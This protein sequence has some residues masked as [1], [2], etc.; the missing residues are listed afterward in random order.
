MLLCSSERAGDGAI[1]VGETACQQ[2]GQH[3]AQRVDVAGGGRC[4]ARGG[5][6]GGDK[7]DAL[8]EC[9]KLPLVVE[10][11][12]GWMDVRFTS[13]REL[14]QPHG[15]GVIGGCVPCCGL[16]NR[17]QRN[18]TMHNAVA[19][20]FRN[21]PRDCK[22]HLSHICEPPRTD[23]SKS[24][25]ERGAFHCFAD[26]HPAA[27][28]LLQRP[29]LGDHWVADRGRLLGGLHHRFPGGRIVAGFCLQNDQRDVTP[30]R[31]MPG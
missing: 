12:P 3:A 18:C 7:A 21:R 15:W 30:T 2:G 8:P 10:R 28:G 27:S 29:G 24:L 26:D 16:K 19:V 31:L 5:E 22:N 25:A 11:E 13:Q 9:L 6:F 20:E 4:T 17:V 14:Q 23:V 1:P